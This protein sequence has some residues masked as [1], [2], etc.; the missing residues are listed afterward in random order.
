LAKTA[1]CPF[2][3]K[4]DLIFLPFWN[5]GRSTMLTC[6]SLSLLP[7]KIKFVVWFRLVQATMTCIWDS[8]Q[9]KTCHKVRFSHWLIFNVYIETAFTLAFLNLLICF[10]FQV[11]FDETTIIVTEPY[12]NF[13]SIQE[14]MNEVL[15]EEYQF[16][17]AHRTN[18]KKWCSHSKT[19]CT[20]TG[21]WEFDVKA[22]V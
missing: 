1:P 9:N 15:F 17:A 8:L 10:Q 12:F 19:A 4:E 16:R 22:G 3:L 20:C 7:L 6:S 14:T 13:L 5:P 21:T 11:R 18:G 2:P